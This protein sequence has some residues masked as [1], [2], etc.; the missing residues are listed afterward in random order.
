[1]T[2]PQLTKAYVVAQPRIA[3]AV[4]NEPLH[5]RQC[6]ATASV[7]EWRRAELMKQHQRHR[8]QHDSSRP[9]HDAC[10][11]ATIGT[12]LVALCS[13]VAA[14]VASQ[15][16]SDVPVVADAREQERGNAARWRRRAATALRHRHRSLTHSTHA[17]HTER[18]HPDKH[19]RRSTGQRTLPSSDR[20]SLPPSR[21]SHC[22]SDR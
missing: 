11:A 2:A 10:K 7:H 1:V 17:A 9:Q 8:S 3:A 22:T 19:A 5:E 16:K 13:R 6:T 4:P 20:A 18:S 21:R 14:T 15:P 12:R